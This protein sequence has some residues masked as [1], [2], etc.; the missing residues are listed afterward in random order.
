M[1]IEHSEVNI[2]KI[3]TVLLFCALHSIL[4]SAS[5]PLHL[6]LNSYLWCGSGTSFWNVQY[7]PENVINQSIYI[8]THKGIHIKTEAFVTLA[9][10]VVDYGQASNLT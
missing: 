3:E 8:K 9:C 1:N 4:V 7:A 2:P 5:P 6:P 10:M